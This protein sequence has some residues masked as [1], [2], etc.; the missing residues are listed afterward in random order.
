MQILLL[1]HGATDWN[2]Q[3]RCQG[4]TDMELNSV[5]LQQA[6]EVA[7]YLGNERIHAVY[8]SNL[9]RAIQTAVAISEPRNLAV[10]IDESLREL[11]HGKLE[12]LTFSEIQAQY[13]R[14]IYKWRNEPAELR[15]PGGERLIDVGK[16]AWDG[17]NRIVRRHHTGETIAIVS[18]NFPILTILCRITETPLNH[19]RSFHLNPC[20]ISRIGYAPECGWR[21]LQINDKALGSSSERT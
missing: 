12:G 10:V 1:R 7:A 2:L 5:G 20:E 8:S 18:H 13:P 9:K 19:Y 11:D 21:V 3:G 17:M 15:V 4:T 14:F 6:R 16:R